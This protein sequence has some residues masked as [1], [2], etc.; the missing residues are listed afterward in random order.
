MANNYCIIRTAEPITDDRYKA[1]QE[2]A[3]KAGLFV[4]ISS[5]DDTLVI[6]SEPFFSQKEP[7]HGA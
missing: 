2:F 6:R 5:Q 3:E 4:I 1:Y 7:E